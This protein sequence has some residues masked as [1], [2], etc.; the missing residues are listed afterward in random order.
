M[1][2]IDQDTCIRPNQT[3]LGTASSG[4]PYTLYGAGATE[5]ISSDEALITSP[6]GFGY[7]ILGLHDVSTINHLGRYEQDNIF[8]GIGP[9]FYYT[10]A[11][12]NYFVALY[13][14]Q[15]QL[16]KM[17]GG[18]FTLM[19][20]VNKS[21]VQGNY[22]WIRVVA[23]SGEI[24]IRA[25]L[26]GTTEG[27]AWD[28]DLQDA[29]WTHGDFGVSWNGNGNPCRFDSLTITDNQTAPPP[30]VV[31]P[32]SA[33]FSLTQK[34]N[35]LFSTIQKL[36][37]SFVLTQKLN[38]TFRSPSMPQPNST[39][40][41]SATVKDATGALVSN[42]S[43]VSVSL[44]FPDGSTTSIVGLG[45]GVV[46]AGSGVY[47]ITYQTKTPGLVR[48]EWKVVASDGTTTGDFINI[49]TVSY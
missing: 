40:Q 13:S 26:D 43:A 42:L 31:V 12:N 14:G 21:L 32:F 24:Q 34:L 48:E 28:I 10:D 36:N 6:T 45:N 20:G 1:S 3:G 11:N 39:I 22:Y 33:S 38:A 7:A 46:N 23:Q 18:V 16:Y 30:P 5:Q 8:Q 41:T 27:S 49:V 29:T 25:W 37:G 35:G 44:S 2:V 17:V 9:T 4:S 19:I 15:I 47:T